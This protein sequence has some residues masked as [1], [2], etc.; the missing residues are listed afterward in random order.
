VLPPLR[1]EQITKKAC[2]QILLN[3]SPALLVFLAT[4]MY[5]IGCNTRDC[6]TCSLGDL[7]AQYTNPN[8]T[9]LHDLLDA[10][11]GCCEK[12][13]WG[14][15]ARAKQGLGHT[16]REEVALDMSFLFSLLSNMQE[17]LLRYPR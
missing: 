8:T 17:Q 6:L 2:V 13:F 5:S 9:T 16:S 14:P 15:R 11:Y 4:H 10:F 7:A 1:K 3:S 12:V